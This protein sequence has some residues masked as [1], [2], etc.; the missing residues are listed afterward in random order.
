[1]GRG[2]FQWS[3]LGVAVAMLFFQQPATAGERKAP[4]ARP[5][6][7]KASTSVALSPAL[8]FAVTS[9]R[10]RTA[11]ETTASRK[12]EPRETNAGSPPKRKTITFFRRGDISV[13]PVIGGVNGAQLS[14]G[15]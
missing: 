3:G 8:G 7:V 12:E 10:D 4:A 5:A 9:G 14:I 11:A 13:Q 6:F 15:F 1:M 2:F